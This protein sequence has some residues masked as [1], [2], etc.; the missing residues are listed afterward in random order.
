MDEELKQLLKR[1][2][3]VTQEIHEIALKTKRYIFWGQ[4]L[5]WLKF[6]IIVVPLIIAIAYAIPFFRHLAEIYN[7]IMNTVGVNGLNGAGT[8]ELLKL[9][10]K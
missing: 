5:G 3:Q 8:Q 6:V 10:S 1:N 2:L 9:L 4:I 7:E